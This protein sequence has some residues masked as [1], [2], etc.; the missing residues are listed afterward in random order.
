[1]K[2]CLHRAV[3]SRMILTL[4]SDCLDKGQ[5]R[6]ESCNMIQVNWGSCWTTPSPAA[7]KHNE[8]LSH[9]SR[10]RNVSTP[11][12]RFSAVCILHNHVVSGPRYWRRLQT[13]W[14]SSTSESAIWTRQASVASSKQKP[15]HKHQTCAESISL[16]KATYGVGVSVIS[17]SRQPHPPQAK[18]SW[19][20]SPIT[21]R[22][23]DL[24][25]WDRVSGRVGNMLDCQ[26]L[27][28]ITSPSYY[29]ARPLITRRE[30]LQTAARPSSGPS[31]HCYCEHR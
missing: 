24:A 12:C 2:F 21:W 14:I 10:S 15:H 29:V 22:E 9:A 3:L 31:P 30:T 6:S 23:E 20:V 11:S 13:C 4:N 18:R 16:S 17:D 5:Q 28:S 1:L 25:T 8:S 26:C 19:Y 7:T 27:C